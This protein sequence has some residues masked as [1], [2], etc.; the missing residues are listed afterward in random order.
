VYL[1][2]T[3]HGAIGK[4]YPLPGVVDRA[5]DE[6]KHLVVEVD[7]TTVDPSSVSG[8]VTRLAHYTPP[9]KLSRHLSPETKKVFEEYL[10]WSGE[11]WAMYEQFKPWYVARLASNSKRWVA[12]DF[13]SSLGLDLYFIGRANELKK[14]VLDLETAELQIKCFADISD[15][16]QDKVLQSTLQ[17]LTGSDSLIKG[18]LDAWK[19]GDVDKMQKLSC[20]DLTKYPE[21]AEYDKGML[22]D[23]N[24]GMANRILEFLERRP[25]PYFVAV[26]S[27]H[28]V[29]KNG[30]VSLLKAKGFDVQQQYDVPEEKVVKSTAN[31]ST[32]SVA[33][34]FKATNEPA[35]SISP[36]TF[37]DKR[38]FPEQFKVSLPMT[39]KRLSVDSSTIR[40][41]LYEPPF[42][43]FVIVSVLV[44]T[45]PSQWSVP[46][47]LLLD[48]LMSTFG[49]TE[50]S[51]RSLTLGGV[52]GRELEC[53]LKTTSDSLNVKGLP[54]SIQLRDESKLK[55]PF[56]FSGS[57]SPL[58]TSGEQT[59]RAKI[60][61]YLAGRRF[62]IL[63]AWGSEE[64]LKT[65]HVDN[66]FDSFEIVGK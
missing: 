48:R 38:S 23:R 36:S 35:E 28:M 44:D 13:K 34:N 18:F 6:A 41:E 49:A 2:G 61:S 5:F 57:L 66:F 47:P 52:P 20:A 55:S 16:A 51:R 43:G 21:L 10:K 45:D 17:G 14:N 24:V 39:P 40:Y 56:G 65:D 30:L 60:R 32:P 53:V 31:T 64:W 62:L 58:F 25:G 54:D 50:I 4:F 15:K 26:G 12:E 7:I 1:L 42:G 8:L 3:I 46:G 63:A 33:E 22:D 37:S 19:T 9:D 59:D 11:T 29:G 27:A